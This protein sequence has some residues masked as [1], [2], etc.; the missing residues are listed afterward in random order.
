MDSILALIIVFWIVS[1]F[2]KALNS[3]KKAG[4]AGKKRVTTWTSGEKA[5]RRSRG[6]A[7]RSRA[8]RPAKLY[9]APTGAA[10][11]PDGQP[12]KRFYGGQRHLRPHA[13][14]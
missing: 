2:G 13:G 11:G 3:K 10:S 12:G 1:A 4:Q 7:A 8:G 5:V 14:A 6:A 9:D